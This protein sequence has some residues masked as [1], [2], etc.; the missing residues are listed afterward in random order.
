[1][2]H[3]V[4]ESEENEGNREQTPQHFQLCR[5]EASVSFSWPLFIALHDIMYLMLMM[6]DYVPQAQFAKRKGYHMF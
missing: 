5:S 6:S 1:M 4:A 2:T 3:Q